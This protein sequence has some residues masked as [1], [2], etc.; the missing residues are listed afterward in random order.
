MKAIRMVVVQNGTK[1]WQGP[2]V[3]WYHPAA[4][5]EG[6]SV[7]TRMMHIRPDDTVL[8]LTRNKE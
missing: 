3:A 2:K 8:I 7:V 1:I 6:P 5:Q 4:R